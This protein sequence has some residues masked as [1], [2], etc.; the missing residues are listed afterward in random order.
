MTMI[1]MVSFMLT[2]RPGIPWD[3]DELID[4]LLK[5]TTLWEPRRYHRKRRIQKKWIKKYGYK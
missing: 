5:D 1:G 3:L 4:D 2:T